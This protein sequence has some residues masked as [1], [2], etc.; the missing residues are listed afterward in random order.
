MVTERAELGL[1][2]R[3]MRHYNPDEHRWPDR[4]EQLTPRQKAELLAFQDNRDV[5][6]MVKLRDALQ[7]VRRAS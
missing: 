1:S 7:F 3:L 6:F 5:S 4:W 2:L